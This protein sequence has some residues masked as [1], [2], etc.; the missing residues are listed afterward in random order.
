[1]QDNTTSAPPCTAF[2]NYYNVVLPAQ[3]QLEKSV[4]EK[5]QFQM[6]EKIMRVHEHLKRTDPA[7]LKRIVKQQAYFLRRDEETAL[8]SL[9]CLIPEKKDRLDAFEIVISVA[10]A[11]SYLDEEERAMLLRIQRALELET[12]SRPN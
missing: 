7:E 2:F 9:A 3:S 4:G 12:P 11:D 8:S 6:I 5:T 10:T 1:M